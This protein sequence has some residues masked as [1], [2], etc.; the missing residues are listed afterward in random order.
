MPK[1]KK[2]AAEEL[3]IAARKL[4]DIEEG[5]SC[6]QTAFKRNGTAFL[7]VGQQGGRHKAMFKLKESR[8]EA[9]Q[10][11]KDSPDGYQVGS[12]SWVTARFS[13]ERPMPRTLWRR[14]LQESYHLSAGN[15]SAGAKQKNVARKQAAKKTSKSRTK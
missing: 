7:Y 3:R 1:A 9:E 13:D 2:D 8:A 11:A 14:W 6:S 5:M 4:P 10:L 15:S 12:T